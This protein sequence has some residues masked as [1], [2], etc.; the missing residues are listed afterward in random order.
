VGYECD[1]ALFQEV[2]GVPWVVE[3]PDK[4]G[5]PLNS[6]VLATAALTDPGWGTRSRDGIPRA[7]SQ[8]HRDHGHLPAERHRLHLGDDGLGQR[9]E[10]GCGQECG[11][12]PKLRLAFYAG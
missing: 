10:E 7:P 3:E 12:P 1:G 2:D 6:I 9:A 11:I 4:P 8:G 5:Q